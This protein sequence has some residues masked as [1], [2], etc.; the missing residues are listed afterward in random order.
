MRWRM[1]FDERK[2]TTS[3]SECAQ[4]YKEKK[5]SSQERPMLFLFLRLQVLFL[6]F[7]RRLAA[8][9]LDSNLGSPLRLLRQLPRF[10]LS[11]RLYT[12]LSSNSQH[13]LCFATSV[14]LPLQQLPHHPLPPRI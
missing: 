2:H 10:A 6:F 1:Q 4:K 12:L 3:Q 14:L 13:T 9:R 7:R 8:F 5:C 11:F